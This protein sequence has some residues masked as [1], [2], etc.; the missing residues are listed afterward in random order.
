MIINTVPMSAQ[1][2]TTTCNAALMVLF[3]LSYLARRFAMPS[4]FM[5]VSTPVVTLLT[6]ACSVGINYVGLSNVILSS[7]SLIIVISGSGCMTWLL[8]DSVLRVGERPG[9]LL[10]LSVFAQILDQILV[11]KAG[12]S[13]LLGIHR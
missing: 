11:D 4:T 12:F 7:L 13:P 8:P 9:T 5:H 2:N 3:I 10:M 1:Q 6:S